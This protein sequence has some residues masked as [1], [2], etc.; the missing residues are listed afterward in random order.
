[1]T[2]EIVR[3]IAKQAVTDIVQVI[4]DE[5]TTSG[6]VTSE[7]KNIEVATGETGLLEVW[8]IGSETSGVGGITGRYIVHV[9]KDNADALTIVSLSALL[10]DDIGAAAVTISDDGSGN[11]SIEVT[12]IATYDINWLCY[13]T[14]KSKTATALP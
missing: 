1:V 4:P 11:V 12:G 5:V 10:Q 8:I 7:I 3:G 13:A 6:A 2:T 14:Y 9:N